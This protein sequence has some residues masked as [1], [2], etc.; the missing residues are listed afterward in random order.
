MPE[1]NVNQYSEAISIGNYYMVEKL[2]E[3]E[4]DE[5]RKKKKQNVYNEKK[6]L[7]LDTFP[8]DKKDIIDKTDRRNL[9]CNLIE[10]EQRIPFLI[11][12]S[13]TNPFAPYQ[14]KLTIL[15]TKCTASDLSLPHS[16]FCHRHSI[17]FAI[18]F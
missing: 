4:K 3:L 2:M 15:P 8:E 10:E 7:L 18:C 16:A 17:T 14:L 5:K 12:L 13:F 1:Q 11:D 9:F 6:K